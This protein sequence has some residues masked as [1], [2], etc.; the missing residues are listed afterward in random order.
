MVLKNWREQSSENGALNYKNQG[1]QMSGRWAIKRKHQS[2]IAEPTKFIHKA[3]SVIDIRY[4]NTYGN[5]VDFL[6]W[7]TIQWKH[8]GHCGS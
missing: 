3:I 1:H 2:I 5:F 8:S 7:G 4:L 6:S